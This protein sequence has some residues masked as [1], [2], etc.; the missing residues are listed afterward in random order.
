MTAVFYVDTNVLLHYR[1][2]TEVDWFTICPDK[3]IKQ[4]CIRLAPAVLDDLDKL[5]YSH[6]SKKIRH[7]ITELMSRIDQIVET[8]AREI[9]SNIFLEIETAEPGS[10]I[11]QKYRLT[12]LSGDD[13]LLASILEKVPGQQEFHIYLVTNDILLK[14]KARSR[15]LAVLTLPSEFKLQEEPDSR[16]R[17]IAELKTLLERQ[18]LRA[19]DLKLTFPDS[20]DWA[21]VRLS[22][23][24][25]ASQLQIE[26]RLLEIRK[27]YPKEDQSI[28]PDQL[29][30][31]AH[32]LKKEDRSSLKLLDVLG[33]FA[34]EACKTSV[35]VSNMKLDTFYLDYEA[36]LISDAQYLAELA[37]TIQVPLMLENTGTCPAD[38]VDINVKFPVGLRLLIREGLPQRPSPPTPPGQPKTL[39]LPRASVAQV[40]SG[41]QFIFRS[42]SDGTVCTINISRLKHLFRTTLPS[43]YI[44][45]ENENAIGPFTIQYVLHASNVPHQIEGELHLNIT[46]QQRRRKIS[47]L[48]R[49]AVTA[50][51]Q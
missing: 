12:C 5:K 10:K 17:Q 47:W 4:I 37:R 42:V 1:H 50:G 18:A 20:N 23:N 15:N 46:R 40:Q 32:V 22:S 44:V 28:I 30:Q 45:F 8:T 39:N 13:R 3:C 41:S 31:Y 38:D 35:Q 48:R 51:S 9:R 34:L 16:D 14:H 25:S 49:K 27:A 36:Y 26:A 29:K 33:R 6:P 19:P 24:P 11:Y 21:A 7:R 43:L 2:F